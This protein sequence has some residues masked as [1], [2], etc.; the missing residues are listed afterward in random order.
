MSYWCDQFL[1]CIEKEKHLCSLNFFFLPYTKRCFVPKCTVGQLLFLKCFGILSLSNTLDVCP[2]FS[3][4]CSK[5]HWGPVRCFFFF[6][7]FSSK[8]TTSDLFELTWLRIQNSLLDECLFPTS[9]P[10]LWPIHVKWWLF[11][12]WP[13]LTTAGWSLTQLV[14]FSFLLLL[15]CHNEQ[16]FYTFMSLE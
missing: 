4:Y 13:I 14:T 9:V 15:S 12:L 7:F 16:L 10:H 8:N 5:Q 2:G 11:V 6:V 1:T 3:L